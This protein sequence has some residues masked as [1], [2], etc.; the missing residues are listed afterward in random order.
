VREHRTTVRTIERA[1]LPQRS[2]LRVVRG[3]S[4]GTILA[5]DPGEYVIG[6]EAAAAL[7]LT[8]S[9]VSRRHAKLVVG[10]DAFAVVVDLGSTNGTFV[11]AARIESAP[12]RIGY[13]LA[14][15]PDAELLVEARGETASPSAPELTPRELDV[16]RLVAQ[17]LTNA[18][19]AERLDIGR[20]TVA[21]HLERIYRRFEIGSRA[22]LARRLTELGWTTP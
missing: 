17:G 11:N 7:R 1:D 5:L 2:Q 13:T 9:G 18:E 22:E 8:D 19:I 3:T 6:R 14:I 4:T 16:A 20:R 12:L 21:T 15:G 10:V